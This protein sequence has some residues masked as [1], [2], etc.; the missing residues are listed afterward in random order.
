MAAPA[1][2]RTIIDASADDTDTAQ[3]DFLRLCD[4]LVSDRDDGLAARLYGF[5]NKVQK[6]IGRERILLSSTERLERAC[7]EDYFSTPW[8]EADRR[9]IL[10][11]L[12]Y[13]RAEYENALSLVRADEDMTKKFESSLTADLELMDGLRI[14][15]QT[16]YAE[17]AELF[18]A[19]TPVRIGRNS[20]S[21]P[22][23]GR[24]QSIRAGFSDY[25]KELGALLAP[26]PA[27]ISASMS[28]SAHIMRA[29]YAV[30]SDFGEEFSAEKRRR[31]IIDYADAENL[32]LDLLT[33]DGEPTA[34]AE[35]IAS[36]Y[37]EIYIDE[38]QDIN[39]VQDAIFSALAHGNRFMVGDIKQSIYRFRGAEPDIFSDYR[40]RFAKLLHPEDA[41]ED[42]RTVFLS[43][44][45][46]CDRSVTGFVNDVFRRIMTPLC[47]SA[48][49]YTED[50]E[51]VCSKV[52]EK[53]TR[54]EAR[55]RIVLIA[56]EPTFDA[57]DGSE[58]AAQ[59]AD[60]SGGTDSTGD[61]KNSIA[62]KSGSSA[63]RDNNSI[64]EIS[65]PEV[66]AADAE[67]EYVAAESARLIRSGMYSPSDI[68]ILTRTSSR[69]GE[70]CPRI[71]PSRRSARCRACGS[72]FLA[73]SHSARAR[74]AAHDRQSAPQYSAHL[75]PAQP[76]RR[77]FPRRADTD[78]A[79]YNSG[80]RSGEC[81][82]APDRK[83]VCL[84]LR[85]C[86]K[87]GRCQGIVL[88]LAA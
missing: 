48:L 28:E 82:H 41:G 23:L 19:Y 59:G 65:A 57:D 81:A 71:S 5:Y 56:P 18:A 58:D 2:D 54:P 88:P 26:S 52:E 51:L 38:Y 80:R 77:L 40:S 75:G 16:G 20:T 79:R 63:D 21:S 70:L 78:K 33:H 73:P 44:N 69:Q 7:R 9:R 34:L 1:P 49:S 13:Y 55:T 74:T 66:S 85:L 30:I 31:G 62:D 45:F 15:A 84:A 37:D 50:D 14:A 47:G 72:V 61:G 17:T 87:D 22:D 6:F 27:A 35:R 32:T 68:R 43:N 36:D 4:L 11:S 60:V 86:R 29:L 64:D 83:Y 42:G 3:D 76:D 53:R 67:A 39:P 24:V 12:D 10:S 25:R 46:R 8:G